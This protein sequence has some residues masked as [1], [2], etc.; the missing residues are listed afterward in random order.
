MLTRIKN[1]DTVEKLMFTAR[2]RYISA[3]LG[4][5][6]FFLCATPAFAHVIVYPHQVGI[7]ATQDFTVSVP[8]ERNNPVVSVR[9]LLPKG[10]SDVLPDATSGWSITT[11]SSGNG[12]AATVSEIDWTNGSIPVGQRAEFVFQA[13]A[14]A[15]TTTLAWKAYQTYSDGTVVSWDVNP[16]K[17]AS[18]SDAQQD[19][20][21]DKENKGEY[22]TTQVIND[23]AAGN[24]ETASLNAALQTAQMA[25]VFA[26][27]AVIVSVA[28]L[29]LT[30][31]NRK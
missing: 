7:A 2:L 27:V 16:Q 15:Q 22:S 10:L 5:I 14:P 6:G 9:L 11:K 30:W 4:A 1:I 3:V 24:A 23:L 13:Q 18:L 19:E 28:A 12:A 31:K 8:N 20:L 21:A 25:E 29:Y 26:A 17:M